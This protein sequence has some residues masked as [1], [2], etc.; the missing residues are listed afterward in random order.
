MSD[1]L[2]QPPTWDD[3]NENSKTDTNE[4]GFQND[5]LQQ[6]INHSQR[7]GEF[8]E[9]FFNSWMKKEYG[10]AEDEI[11][12]LNLEQT[13]EY[14]RRQEMTDDDEN[15][16]V[17]IMNMMTRQLDTC[18][19]DWMAFNGGKSYQIAERVREKRSGGSTDFTI[20]TYS[21]GLK[22]EREKLESAITDDHS[23]PADLYMFFVHNDAD[24]VEYAA[25][26]DPERLGELLIEERI[27]YDGPIPNY[28]TPDDQ[29]GYDET[30]FIAISLDEL[31]E[32]ECIIYET[33]ER[34]V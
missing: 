6:Q 34:D 21:S 10:A 26:I 33:G 24:V 9:G 12:I 8:A 5:K 23:S 7:F 1:A 27:E 13:S 30:S 28:S 4:T 3:E 11:T 29:S 20:R 2:T 22:T 25:L 32:N 16:M 31:D 15:E 18:G 19:I 17:Q 14:C